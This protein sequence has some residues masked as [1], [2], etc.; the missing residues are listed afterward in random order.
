MTTASTTDRRRGQAGA[1]GAGRARGPV[2]P[3]ARPG[4]G[5]RARRTAGAH[6]CGQR[7]GR[8][9][10]SA[11]VE[12]D[13][14]PHRVDDQDVHCGHGA[15]ACATT[16]CWRWTTRCP[17]GA[18]APDVRFATDHVAPPP[19]DAV[20]S[21][22]R[23]PVGGPP[24]RHHPAA[25]DDVLAGGPLRLRAG[26]RLRVLQPRLRRDRPGRRADHRP[27]GAG[28]RGRAPAR[29]RWASARTTWVRPA[30]DDWARPHRVE[31]GGPSPTTVPLGDGALA[32]MGGLWSTVEDL[33][34]VVRLV[35]R[36][37]PGPRR[38]RRRAVATIVT[39]RAAAGAAGQRAGPHR[40][41]G[42]GDRPRPGAH[43][44]RRI[45]LRAA[46]HPRS[47]VRPHR[48]PLRRT[49]RLRLEHALAARAPTSASS[50]SPTRRTRRCAC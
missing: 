22:R 20:R 27:P 34:T 41:D 11:P 50:P 17:T 21:D 49:A 8:P 45:R 12:P 24:S 4:V 32:P 38:R 29:R 16:G 46:G 9:R 3:R 10:S 28:P 39:T 15:R 37:L 2:A 40:G 13:R 14:V 5:G 42:R 36:R 43:R 1:R 44:R 23:R 19:V 47:A 48:R 26:A 31:D 6:G 30:D 18:D 33:A 35:R 25:L 7:L